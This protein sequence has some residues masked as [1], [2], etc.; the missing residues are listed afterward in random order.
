[1]KGWGWGGGGV[2]V[3]WGLVSRQTAGVSTD[4]YIIR[5]LYFSQWWSGQ[6]CW[7]AVVSAVAVI[8]V[9]VAG[10]DHNS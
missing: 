4:V 5:G 6:R 7:S 3:V 10:G 8:N 9:L 1:M 2:Q